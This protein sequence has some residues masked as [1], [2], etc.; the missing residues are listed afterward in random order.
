MI[1][2]AERTQAVFQGG[3]MAGRASAPR[4]PQQPHRINHGMSERSGTCVLAELEL[5]KNAD[6]RTCHIDVFVQR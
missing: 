2:N 6:P 5:Q 1:Q 3:W 4:R